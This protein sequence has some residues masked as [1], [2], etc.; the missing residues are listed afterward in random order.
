[1]H[2][3]PSELERAQRALRVVALVGLVDL[4]LLA[5]LVA[6]AL[7]DADGLT[8]VLG[9][10][11]GVGFLTELV[12]VARGAGEGWWGWWYLAAVLVTG[13]PL[14]LALGHGRA[15]REVRGRLGPPPEVAAVGSAG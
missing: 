11:H 5:P 13:G 2:V 9:P 7:L 14:G 8:S 15:R 1:M 10:L 6:G 4:A 12:L 3:A